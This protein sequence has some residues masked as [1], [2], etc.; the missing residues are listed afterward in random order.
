MAK[1]IVLLD[2]NAAKELKK[3]PQ[4]VVEILAQ[5]RADLESDGPTPKGWTV[6]HVKGRSNTLAARLKRE[7]RA[8][9][10]VI[11]P[12]IIIISVAHRKEAY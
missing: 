1:W 3:L 11:T 7:Y 9:Y 5:L 2:K 12:S 10:E 4:E 8:L 6:K